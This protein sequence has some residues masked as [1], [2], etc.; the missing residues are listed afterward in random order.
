MKKLV[1]HAVV[2]MYLLMTGW[3]FL[4]T[5]A[6]I[7]PPIGRNLMIFS[8]AMMAPFQGYVTGMAELAA[9]GVHP[10]GT[11]EEIDLG[12]YYPTT[13]G[14]RLTRGYMNTYRVF[15]GTHELL[16]AY[17]RIAQLLADRERA[18]GKDYALAVPFWYG[19]P[20]SPDGLFA[21]RKPPFLERVPVSLEAE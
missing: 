5:L 4:Y 14:E 19:W 9:E 8:Y 11:R 3:A 1:R 10:D 6:R 17:Q 2:C 21:L 13:Y 15:H 16:M 7:D 12:P 18:N 20:M